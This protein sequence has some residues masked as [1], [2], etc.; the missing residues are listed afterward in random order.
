MIDYLENLDPVCLAAATVVSW[1]ISSYFCYIA[2]SSLESRQNDNKGSV[3]HYR[4]CSECGHETSRIA[5]QSCVSCFVEKMDKLDQ[6]VEI[7]DDQPAKTAISL[8][9]EFVNKMRNDG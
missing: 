2:I 8:P 3:S 4:R 1:I 9:Q 7:E 6:T 5:Y